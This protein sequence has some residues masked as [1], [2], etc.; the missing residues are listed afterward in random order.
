MRTAR[1]TPACRDTSTVGSPGL[2]WLWNWWRIQACC[3]DDFFLRQLRHLELLHPQQL[4]ALQRSGRVEELE[5]VTAAFAVRVLRHASKARD[6][7]HDVAIHGRERL[8]PAHE[9]GPCP[10]D[11]GACLGDLR[12]HRTRL[13]LYFC[14]GAYDRAA[15][16]I[17]DRQRDRHAEECRRA[18]DLMCQQ[19]AAAERRDGEALSL[20]KQHT[21]LCSDLLALDR[22]KCRTSALRDVPERIE[23]R[24]GVARLQ[25]AIRPGPPS[26]E[27]EECCEPPGGIVDIRG[28]I[29]DLDIEHSS[30]G[31]DTKDVIL[32]S[33]ARVRPPAYD[34]LNPLQFNAAVLEKPQLFLTREQGGKGLA[35]VEPSFSKRGSD[36]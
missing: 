5:N 25:A 2:T 4:D 10:L 7:L 14:R 6:T 34:L 22:E 23:L 13:G 36:P 35:H 24:R 18:G 30:L 33:V 26:S 9:R 20:G 1:S 28:R 3:G 29:H 17:E 31:F 19:R 21:S 8:A 27:P 15:I 11:L 32:T 16:A 12:A